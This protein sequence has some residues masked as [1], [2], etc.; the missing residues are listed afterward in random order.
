MRHLKGWGVVLLLSAV[1][2]S[3]NAQEFRATVNGRV[4]DATGAAVPG[5]KVTATNTA[6]NETASTT[7]LGE[8][9]YTIPLL[10]PG[11]YNIRSESQGFKSAVRE[12]IQL[13]VGDTKTV[14]FSLQVGEVQESSDHL[15]R[16]AAAG[17]DHGDARRS[18]REP[19]RHR[20]AD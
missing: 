13:F 3:L 5:A 7:A 2:C 6:T 11:T 10:K 9:D 8:G 19:S 14:D 1:L 15:G 16:A 20:T 12:N 17:S 4:T 18:S